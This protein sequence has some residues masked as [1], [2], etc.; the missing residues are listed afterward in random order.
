MKKILMATAAIAAMTT[1][2]FASDLPNKKVAPA[3][4]AATATSSD[5]LSISYGQDFVNG[6]FGTK[7]D[8]A[9]GVTYTHK[10]DAFS[11]GAAI[12]T[13]NDTSNTLKQNIEGQV[14]YSVPLL[15]NVTATGKVG[16][17][18]R[19]T[20]TDFPYYALYGA[21]DYKV[22]DDLTLNA[23]SYR[24]RSAF[25]SAANGYQ[26]HQLGTGVTYNLNKSY[27]VSTKV[28]RNWD[29]DYNTTG[30][31]ATMALNIKF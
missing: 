18:E 20:S 29:E 19:F 6:S 12:S 27:S 21:A 7:A 30:D 11:I 31:S 4:P 1:V 9:Y 15:A 26:S 14:G 5:T 3:A 17:G 24:Y 8:D 25:D 23:V 10:I 22:S 16:I 2:A 13:T 28:A